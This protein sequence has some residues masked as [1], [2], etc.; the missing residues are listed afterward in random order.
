MSWKNILTSNSKEFEKS[1]NTNI[2]NHEEE[3]YDIQYDINVKDVDDEFENKYLSK[4]CD[5]KTDFRLYLEEE[6]LQFLNKTNI[7]GK[8]DFHDYIK[9]NSYN[10]YKLEK[11]INDYNEECMKEYM[12][13]LAEEEIYDYI[14]EYDN[15]KKL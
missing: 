4:I 11:E 8:F 7:G 6:H 14:N 12:N 5:I 3:E 13:E 1:L 10:F 9:F 15:Q 2:E